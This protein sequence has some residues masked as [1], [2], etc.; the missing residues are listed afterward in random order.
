MTTQW[1]VGQNLSFLRTVNLHIWTQEARLQASYRRYEV[2]ETSPQIQL[3]IDK[4]MLLQRLRTIQTELSTFLTREEDLWAGLSDPLGLPPNSFIQELYDNFMETVVSEGSSLFRHLCDEPQFGEYIKKIN[5]LPD[6]SSLMIETD[7]ALLPWEIL[8][9]E[10][11][12]KN[13]PLDR[14]PKIQ[15]ER[16]WGHRFFIEYRLLPKNG[17]R[18]CR[19]GSIAV[20]R[21]S[22]V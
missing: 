22:L 12:D 8:Y 13:L 9:P 1:N 2:E 11:Y 14:R 6:G 18:V 17:Y 15:P 21:H 10:P 4:I 19:P 5:E 16:L 3:N 7:C 20:Q